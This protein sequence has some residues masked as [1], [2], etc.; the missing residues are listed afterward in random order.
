ML[1]LGGFAATFLASRDGTR[2]P[3]PQKKL[4]RTH[5]VSKKAIWPTKTANNL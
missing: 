3:P 1:I 5:E 4:P 2:D